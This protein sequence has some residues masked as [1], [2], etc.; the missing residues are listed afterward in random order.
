M[1]KI[2]Y[3]LTLFI[4]LN[5]CTTSSQ[6][7]DQKYSLYRIQVDSIAAPDSIILGGTIKLQFYGVVGT[8][9][10]HSFS[11]FEAQE[12][13]YQLILTLWGQREQADACP[14]VMVYL[15]GKEYLVTPLQRGLYTVTVNQPDLSFLHRTIFVD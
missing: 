10:C 7:E 9:G 4:L 15:D 11:H 2:L 6:P 13:P 12:D 14:T 5:T 3:Y 1:H 8:D